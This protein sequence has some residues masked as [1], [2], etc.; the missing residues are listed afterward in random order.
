M[1]R[2]QKLIGAVIILVILITGLFVL[3]HF[4]VVEL[5]QSVSIELAG[6]IIVAFSTWALT[7]TSIVDRDS[8]ELRLL[9]FTIW[10]LAIRGPKHF[11]RETL[12][13]LAQRAEGIRDD[14]RTNGKKYN[15]ITAYADAIR[16]FDAY[17]IKDNPQTR[18]KTYKAA[19]EKVN[20]QL[21]LTLNALSKKAGSSFENSK[22][23]FTI[24]IENEAN[25]PTPVSFSA[26]QH[27][28]STETQ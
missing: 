20:N 11:D 19:W 4:A 12:P 23:Q 7:S 8:R 28:T 18:S 2:I 10:Q 21:V 24:S 14:Y 15:K 22:S 6:A 5:I 17:L 26:G 13:S 1:E 27:H 3:D 9:H 16:A 25:P